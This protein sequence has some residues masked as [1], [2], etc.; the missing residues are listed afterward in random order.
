MHIEVDKDNSQVKDIFVSN[1][2][3]MECYVFILV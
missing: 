1:G 2:G 3:Q